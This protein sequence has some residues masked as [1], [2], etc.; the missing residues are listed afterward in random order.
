MAH[1][2]LLSR[3][4]FL[5]TA[6]ALVAPPFLRGADAQPH[7]VV[8]DLHSQLNETRVR[9]ILTPRTTADVQAAVRAAAAEGTS[10]SLC[11]SRH[12][13]GG[14]QFGADTLL[15]DLRSLS[16]HSTR[17]AARSRSRRALSG[18]HSSARSST[19][20][21]AGPGSGA[22]RRNRPVPIG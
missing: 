1:R 19:A 12:A 9:R 17:S 16:G 3:R 8:N 21:A 18:R 15:I 14:Q 7:V 11:G 5:E 10:V 4:A 22:S 6:G 20:S 13:M 2:S